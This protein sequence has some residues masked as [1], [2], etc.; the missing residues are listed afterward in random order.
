MKIEFLAKK[1]KVVGAKKLLNLIEN[2]SNKIDS[3]Q[4]I[5]PKLGSRSLGKFL[6]KYE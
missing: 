2:Q 6:V 1:K 5:S 3:V 4:F